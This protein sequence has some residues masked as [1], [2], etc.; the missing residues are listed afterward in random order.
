MLIPS[1][2]PLRLYGFLEIGIALFALAFA[3]LMRLYPSMYPLLAQ[4]K[5]DSYFYL[6]VIRILFSITALLVPTILMGGTLPVLSRFISRQVTGLKRHLSFLYGINTLGA[7][8]GAGAAGFYL[9]RLF[10]VSTTL[11]IAISLNVIIGLVS[12]VLQE[13]AAS[14]EASKNSRKREGAS[15]ADDDA[16]PPQADRAQMFSLKLVLWGIG[17]S[18]FC[19]FGYEVLWSRILTIVVGAS[20]YSFTVMLIAFL[21]G[22]ALGSHAYG[23]LPKALGVEEEG[24]PS[25][26]PGLVSFRFLSA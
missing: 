4:G 10:P 17:V 2:K 14:A 8:F 6:T 22:I 21:S 9:L 20:V 26:S 15:R 3:G 19:A 23:L 25:R 13:K 12:I 16:S 5:D 11:I 1:S 18:G 7:V 24:K